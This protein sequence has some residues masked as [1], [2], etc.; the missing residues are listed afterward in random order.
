MQ[1]L[2]RAEG[3]S[4]GANRLV[5]F[6][7]VLGLLGVHA[8]LRGKVVLAVHLPHLRARGGHGLRAEIGGVGTHV[9]DVPALVQPL[10]GA[11]GAGGGKAQ[12][13]AAFLLQRGRDERRVGP[14][15]EGFF[16]GAGHGER[17]PGQAVRQRLRLG[18]GQQADVRAVLQFAG[19]RVE[20]LADRQ[21]LS[22]DVGQAGGKG[23]ALRRAAR[24]DQIPPGRRN[25][26]HPFALPLYQHAGRHALHA[27]RAEFGGDLFP[28]HRA[29]LVAVQAV[30]GAP[31]LLRFHQVGV[32]LPGRG[33]GGLNGLARDL[34]KDHAL[35]RHFRLQFL[36][37]VPGDALALAVVVGRQNDLVGA[38]G[39]LLELGDMRAFFRGHHVQ[40]LEVVFHVQAQP[41]PGLALV[42]LGDVRRTLGQVADVPDAGL[43]RVPLSEVFLDGAGLGRR[44][45]DD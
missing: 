38:G 25:E 44:F 27:A 13:A 35:D 20:V 32:D 11:H 15:R 8:R 40:R 26:A 31:G 1:A 42:L 5:R 33:N 22:G 39:Q 19:E 37:Q 36:V 17:L 18:P 21:L 14:L 7:G 23:R 12:F 43:H 45:D 34:V 3:A 29:D 6:L 41:R 4:G 16:L 9:G 2:G 24:D 28:Q 10:R 30:Q